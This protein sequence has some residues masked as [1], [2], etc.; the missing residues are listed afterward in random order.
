MQADD[1]SFAGHLIANAILPFNSWAA[2]PE[3]ENLVEIRHVLQKTKIFHHRQA[4]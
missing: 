3:P 1:P 4:A 2:E